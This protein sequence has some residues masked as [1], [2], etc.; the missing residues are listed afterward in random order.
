MRDK[1][2]EFQTED[3][4]YLRHGSRALA[5]RV[6]RPRGDGPFP[7]VID[8]HGGAWCNGDLD[9]CRARDKV[10]AGS[11][12]TAIAIDFRHADDGYPTSLIDINYAIRWAKANAT[13]LNIR[14][15]L[16][17]VAG[18]SSGGHLAMLAAMRPFDA[19]YAAVALPAGS[20]AVDATVRCVAMLWPVINPLSRYRHARRARDA[21]SPPAWVGDL[22][23]RHDRYWKNEPN[24]AEGNPM[25]ALERG[26]KVATSPAIWVQ[27]KPD[28][29][30]DYRDP[31]SPI[32]G[33]EPERFATNYRKAGGAL[34]LVYVDYATRMGQATHDL[35]TAFFH[36]HLKVT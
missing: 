26:E 35:V 11:G 2:Y 36:Q 20:P 13:K 33:N 17:S 9:E 7:A 14:P 16:V 24:M 12:L 18:Q 19:R 27:G 10:L 30:H 6:Y 29:V 21:A 34:E 15:D 1:T 23:E 8:I 28:P 5:L 4:E 3:Y 32:P 22:P 31:E 25:L